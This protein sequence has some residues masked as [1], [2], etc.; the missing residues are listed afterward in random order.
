MS[1]GDSRTML[2]KRI[3]CAG[4]APR[5]RIARSAPRMMLVAVAAACCIGLAGCAP[6]NDALQTVES[7][8][9][10]VS[11][12]DASSSSSAAP[13]GI[14]SAGTDAAAAETAAA[15]ASDEAVSAADGLDSAVQAN[16][17]AVSDDAAGGSSEDTGSS[18]GESS[19]IRVTCT[20]SSNAADGSVNA[21]VSAT[22]PRGSTA[23]DALG[24][25]GLSYSARSSQYG[26]YIAAIG[27]LTEK[28]SRFGSGSG[29]LYA[30]NGST[31]GTSAGNY[32]L[33]DGDDVSWFFTRS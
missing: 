5:G 33:A 4:I 15:T 26:T 29:W 27:G 20:V 9:V 28:D 18:A 1:R 24:A 11:A 23:L 12:S 31:P 16:E 6:G 32:V 30:V 2:A 13:A 22:L 7:S 8:S 14:S 10:S 25:T 21:S 3:R 17:E 19:V